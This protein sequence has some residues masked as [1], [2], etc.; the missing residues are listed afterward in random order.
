MSETVL[1]SFVYQLRKSVGRPCPTEPDRELLKRFAAT[2]D[3]A[4]FAELVARYGGL[5][6][7]VCRN[8]L[9]N[10]A[11]VDE[12]MQA[13]F[14][15]LAR[16]S[17]GL[18]QPDA[19]AGWLH[20]VAY[21]TALKLRRA[22]ARRRDREARSSGVTAQSA[23]PAEASWR[24]LQQLLD[25]EL[26]RL[27]EKLRAPFVL[28]CLDRHSKSEAALLL[29]WKTGTV[30]GRLD[31]ARKLLRIRLGRRGISLTAVLCGL[32][33]SE[34]SGRS[35]LSSACRSRITAT[36]LHTGPTAD[37]V[38]GT[39]LVRSAVRGSIVARAGAW[40]FAIMTLAAIGA[41]T[42]IMLTP[43][44]APA[45]SADEAPASP[46]AREPQ[47]RVD[48]FG[49][50]LPPGAIARLG[51]K[52][53]GHSFYTD[54]V[55]WSPDG[56]LL[57]T[58]GGYSTGRRL[59]LWDVATGREI[60]ELPAQG[61]VAAAA[62]S[63]DGRTLAAMEG[64]RTV[65][66]DVRTGREIASYPHRSEF[67]A[68]AF[69]PDGLTFAAS[70]TGS[71][72]K[73]WNIS[74]RTSLKEI[75]GHTKRLYDLSYSPDG[76]K[77]LSTAEDCTV[78]LWGVASAT[79]IWQ[80]IPADKA[81]PVVRF[82][83]DGKTIATADS[84]AAVRILD[85]NTGKELRSFGGERKSAANA[86]A[87]SPDGRMLAEGGPHDL[88]RL[89]NPQ[90]GELIRSWSGEVLSVRALQFS[91]DGRTL[92]SAGVWGTPV[93]FWDPATGKTTRP[94]SGHTA[95]VV[96]MKFSSDGKTLWSRGR[97]YALL[98]WDVATGKSERHFGG[99][100]NGALNAVV[101]S[102]DGQLIASC[103]RVDRKIQL[104]D[105]KG[106]E[107]AL[108]GSHAGG[109]LGGAFSRDGKLL[110]TGC[111]E[112]EVC[113]WDIATRK[114]IRRIQLPK[115]AWGNF[116]FSPDGRRLVVGGNSSRGPTRNN[117]P[118]IVEVASGKE[119]VKL[120]DPLGEAYVRFSPDSQTV[121]VA[122]GY[123]DR[124]I[125]LFDAES[126]KEKGR[127]LMPSA[128]WGMEF[129]PDSRYLATG[130]AERDNEIRLWETATC[131]QVASFCG[132]HSGVA[133][134]AFKP[135]GR[136]LA[137]GGGDA[138]ILLWDLT[139]RAPDSKVIPA[140]LAQSRL[141]ECWDELGSDAADKAYQAVRELASNPQ[142]T[143]PFLATKLKPIAA[144]DGARVARLIA[145][146]D[147]DKFDV[148]ESA[149][150]E[151]L[152]AGEAVEPALRKLLDGSPAA[153]SQKRAER[154]L[155]KL[156]SAPPRVRR[157]VAVL[158]YC[159]TADSHR[160]LEKLARESADS[161]I[162]EEAGVA[163]ERMSKL[164]DK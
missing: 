50:A 136:M 69:A 29:G 132:H 5:V 28:C 15:L 125:R 81:T 138:T 80:Y 129:S 140:P 75:R 27:P 118:R 150:A 130:G 11:D 42:A 101:F 88:I 87:Y 24:E 123:R 128:C 137:S 89:W 126:G 95:P 107:L 65:L 8:V 100:L 58:I 154:I 61:M 56:K 62:F 16:R 82:S 83:P 152:H 77:L 117:P 149:E 55:Y 38:A 22:A 97:D 34:G 14:L 116:D 114:E 162:K 63:P 59:C 119:L 127:C 86:L 120:P 85:V 124:V 51:S 135:D 160:Q 113:L 143:I 43:P 9:R 12:A 21:R 36:V 156:A 46:G 163:L 84:H 39:G 41:A 157:A 164:A 153:E 109:L 134:F 99:P 105:N 76:S 78:R 66:W 37:V 20:S 158:E 45:S 23:P 108:L 145:E 32:A 115:D 96:E 2:R 33:L 146:L 102:P 71:V 161:R 48:R 64:S 147:A 103:G 10:D 19:L 131:G 13:T 90:S 18:R 35:A 93:R 26:Q 7:T 70:D 72:I 91:P 142:R 44:A 159:G 73:I 92:A 94:V 31:E 79:E 4:A 111:E 112:G 49:D 54:K 141:D 67:Q 68:L 144:P 53:F 17:G 6:R 25:E 139:G 110:V 52:R 57:A 133:S 74:D 30:S 1:R 47:L 121:A 104:W 122:G 3:D 106:V 40:V 148:R 60:H 151:L 155:A 98:S